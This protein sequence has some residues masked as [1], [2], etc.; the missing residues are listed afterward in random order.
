MSNYNIA[1]VWEGA[2][3]LVFSNVTMMCVG[4]RGWWLVWF[5]WYLYL[6]FLRLAEIFKLLSLCLLSVFGAY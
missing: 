2:F 5:V 4:G 3:P 6:F 1:Q